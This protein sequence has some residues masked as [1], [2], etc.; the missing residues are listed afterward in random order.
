N[1]LD[2]DSDGDGCSDSVEWGAVDASDNDTS[3]YRTGTDANENGLLDAFESGTSGTIDYDLV[4]GYALDGDRNGCIDTDDD[5][6]ANMAD[7]DDD[8]DGVLDT[9]ESSC[10]ELQGINTHAM[11]WHGFAASNVFS[12]PAE[13]H[14]LAADIMVN[15][16]AWANA[17]SD[18]ELA[19]PL[20]VE[21]TIPYATNGMIGI[22]PVDR[23]ETNG[24]NDGGYKIQFNRTHGVYV[25]HASVAPGWQGPSV[26]GQT[27]KLE[28]DENGNMTYWKDGSVIFSGIVPQTQYKV[29]L[30]R[31]T[32]AISGFQVSQG[33][34]VCE[35][36]DT[37]SDNTPNSLDLDSD[38]DGC[39]DGVE[40]GS[41]ASEDNDIT[42]FNSGTDANKN[43]LLDQFE[44]GTSGTVNYVPNYGLAIESKV[45]GCLYKDGDG[46]GDVVDLDDD[47]DGVLDALESET[48][49]V[50]TESTSNWSLS[51]GF[52]SRGFYNY[53]CCGVWPTEGSNYLHFN[54][55][56]TQNSGTAYVSLGTLEKAGT[57]IIEIDVLNF[58]NLPFPGTLT[59]HGFRSDGSS[60]DAPGDV[61]AEQLVTAPIPERGETVKWRYTWIVPE[62]DPRIGK[63]FGYSMTVLY[64]RV[65]AN[66]AID[67]LV[68][69]SPMDTDGDGIMNH[70]DLDSDGDGCSD[71]VESGGR[72]ASQN[73]IEDYNSGTDANENGFLDEFEGNN[74][75]HNYRVTYEYALKEELNH[76][77]DTDGDGIG[78]LV[79]IDDDN[80]GI[81]D[82]EESPNCFYSTDDF[83]AGISTDLFAQT[84]NPLEN[85][86]DGN[87]RTFTYF[88][89]NVGSA[90]MAIFTLT[91][92]APMALSAIHYLA[93]SWPINHG[94][95]RSKLQGYNGAEWVDLSPDLF[96]SG[97][98]RTQVIQ[99]T[100]DVNGVYDR[101]RLVITAGS[102]HYG[103]ISEIK[104]IPS[105][106]DIRFGL[107]ENC[108][109][110]TDGDGIA[111]HLDL[112]SDGDGCSDSVEA[113][114]MGINENN[115]TDFNDG[116][117]ANNNGLL[118]EFEEGSTGTL[119][120][121]PNYYL[122]I[123]SDISACEDTDKD[124]IG[125]LVDIDDDNDGVLDATEGCEDGTMER[126]FTHLNRAYLVPSGRYYFDFGT[127]VFEADVDNSEGGGWVLILQYV[128]R[129][130]TN[131]SL[132]IIQPGENF[133][134]T[135][136]GTL[137][138][139][140]SGSEYW[141]HTGNLAFSQFAD[142]DELRF[143]GESEANERITHFRTSEGLEYARS[144]SGSFDE[145]AE[146]YVALQGHTSFLPRGASY[147]YYN[148]GNEALTRFPFWYW[149]T[150][151]WGIRGNGNRWEVDDF[152][153]NS[154]RSTIHKVWVRSNT[155]PSDYCTLDTDGDGKDNSIDLD[156]DG[157]ACSD[158]VEAGA[159]PIGENDISNFL[160]GDDLNKNG[161]LDRFEEGTTGQVNYDQDYSL[162]IREGISQCLDTDGDGISDLVDID[163]DN[164]GVTD[165]EEIAACDGTEIDPENIITHDFSVS[166]DTGWDV[167]STSVAPTFNAYGAY[168][169][170][171]TDWDIT[172]VTT[173]ETEP[174][175]VLEIGLDVGK[176]ASNASDRIEV[177]VD[178]QEMVSLS[179]SEITG[180]H[181]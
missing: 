58:S 30:T 143:Y 135:S 107:K 137:G 54:S 53:N 142:A 132:E 141:G 2:L 49:Y 34:G 69:T 35:E 175:D 5:D 46:I 151:H 27:F 149:G 4:Y 117:D 88:R 123:S 120:Y 68:L 59:E 38:A 146:N 43:G 154:T 42:N 110:D 112:D 19:L 17:Y 116:N 55:R 57:Y 105:S 33:Y 67:N 129:G 77:T 7:I 165:D 40:T 87:A 31:G 91:P 172:L 153:G 45:S 75:T 14:G 93:R 166:S 13:G 155:A 130:G 11:T 164:D 8:N 86:I 23:A 10:T 122:A 108:S 126:P 20:S 81:L 71:S 84:S 119:N 61:V 1:H 127:G 134:K 98:S 139:D 56:T 159:L 163:D 24:W 22:L 104:L 95:D 62:S 50:E 6:I 52:S 37:D 128:H 138:D 121:T 26:V 101:F 63:E 145:I 181:S 80:D 170:S 51:S 177:Y 97:A 109:A 180:T 15:G 174:Y 118:D 176:Y 125:D 79:D 158:S 66:M 147:F 179:A 171:D 115:T 32:F 161:L 100:L 157:D 47:N 16:G 72:N 9:T 44:E 124:G 25:R 150:W 28:V 162:A 78:D 70:L 39:D 167:S 74:G 89:P 133:P 64:D 83:I 103:G 106:H 29:V 160:R 169:N 85:A 131:P 178:G 94:A 111:N 41:T 48:T 136:E 36:L 73:N 82:Y 114:A 21:G 152:P 12:F 90:G 156:S 113:G 148:R 168:A 3:N 99:N 96:L 18:I 144:G 65:N 140:E 102:V 92:R 60:A 76:C 173:F